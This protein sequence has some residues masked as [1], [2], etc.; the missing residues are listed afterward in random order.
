MLIALGAELVLRHGE[1]IR[2]TPVENYFV[3][4]GKQDRKPGELVW[5]INVP[6]L[7]TNE[8][9]RAYKISKRFDQDISAIMAAFKFTLDGSGIAAARVAFGGMAA[10]P[11]RAPETERA[12]VGLSLANE[13]GWQRAAAALASDFSPIS[14]MRASAAY[15]MDVA[16]SLLRK[17]MIEMA[18]TKATR[19]FGTRG[20]AA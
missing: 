4:Y 3:A 16:Q 9:F 5:Q 18:G 6:R 19:V 1:S 2:S 10:T 13:T 20:E 17:A 11:K 12:L 14:D 15:R 7:A 8:R